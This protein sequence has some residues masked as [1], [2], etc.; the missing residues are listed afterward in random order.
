MPYKV[1]VDFKDLQDGAYAYKVG[2]TF[3]RE[4]NKVSLGRLVELSSTAN[5]RGVVLI[6]EVVEKT[7]EEKP[8]RKR[9]RR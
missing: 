7:T 4:G 1:V 5:K 3:P 9:R 6:E 2:D 8:K